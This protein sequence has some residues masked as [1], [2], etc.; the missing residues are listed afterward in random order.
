MKLVEFSVSNYRSITSAHKIKLQNFTVLVGKNNEGKSNLL[1]AM[2][3][4]MKALMN[5]VMDGMSSRVRGSRGVYDW[6]RDFPLQYQDRRSGVESIFTLSFCLEED[7]LNEFH[8]QTGIRGNEIIPIRVKIGPENNPKIE[9]PKRGTAAYNKKSRQ[10]TDF[11]S[12]RI[13][14]NYIQAIRTEEMAIEALQNVIWSEL[15]M[16]TKNP[17]YM[18][19]MQKVNELQQNIMD[20]IAC[21]L[22]EPLKVFLPNLRNVS[23]R[24]NTDEY[25][26]RYMRSDIEVV[27]DDGIATS[28][29]NKG[30]GIKSLVTLAILKDRRNMQGASIIAIE[31]PESHLHSGAIHSLVD[32]I[33]NMSENNQVIITTHNPLFV[34][35]NKIS[36]NI[37]VNNGTARIAKSI[38]EI[39]SVLGVLPSDNLRNARYILVV[40]G[41]DDK[42]S[43]Q[44]ILPLCSNKIKNALNTNQLIIKPLGGAGNLSH[45]LADL[46][47][48]MCKY[49]VLLDNDKAGIDAADKA[50]SNG[51]L[52]LSEVKYTICNGSPEAEFEDCLRKQVYESVISENFGISINAAEF[53]S[54]DKWSERMKRIFLAQG[55][56]WTDKIEQ[57]VK[58]AVARAIPESGGVYDI[59]IKQKSGFITG[60]VNAIETMLEE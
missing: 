17:E 19:A 25:L 23:I 6:R 7:E 28:I 58:M 44:K 33:Q 24:K 1:T 31:E 40:E 18:E 50:I 22:I 47:N 21:Q 32:V 16:L 10:V 8:V 57:D 5:H 48:C 39:R 34:Q 14:F 59:V 43:L 26:P 35:Q 15:R 51:L 42:I 9:V 3:V 55:S 27:I 60:L 11:I 2:N 36:A 54:N 30:D 20:N 12:Q 13:S 53:G 56:R 4:A 29:R 49:V 45:D 38:A 46:K 37:I 41:E 52:K